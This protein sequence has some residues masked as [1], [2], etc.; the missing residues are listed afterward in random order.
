MRPRFHPQLVNDR[1]GDPAL[2]VDLLFERR[3]LLFDLGDISA[4]PAR[5]VL[6]LSDVFVSHAHIDHFFGFDHL[7]RLF[8]GRARELRLYGPEGFIDRV[9]A[10]LGG[11][12][13]SLAERYDNNLSFLVTE[14]AGNRARRARFALSRRF[15][16]E[17]LGEAALDGA[18]LLDEPSIT[19]RVAELDHGTPVLGFALAEANHVNIWPNRVAEMG[20]ATGPWLTGLKQAVFAGLPDETVIEAPLVTGGSRA[21]PLGELRAW[22]VS[23][24]RGQKIAYVTDVAGTE[25]NFRR[26]VELAEGADTLFIEA[27]FRAADEELARSRQHLT[28]AEAGWLGRMA[29]AA[30]IEPFHFSPRYPEQ[31]AEILAEIEAAFLGEDPDKG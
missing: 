10:R 28:T 9:G 13:W 25:E 2:Y 15:A 26:I 29:R 24:T 30:R 23:I 8:V 11:Y 27:V 31:E 18:L 22:L 3:A 19:V 17:D 20:L 4:L 1:Y 16:R 7:L 21:F 6:R 5:A 12:T 14:I